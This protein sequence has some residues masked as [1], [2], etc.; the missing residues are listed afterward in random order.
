MFPRS[1]VAIVPPTTGAGGR[2]RIT[3]L[4]VL[5]DDM[6]N[7]PVPSCTPKLT[8][9]ALKPAGGSHGSS[10]SAVLEQNSIAIEPTDPVVSTI[11]LTLNV[12]AG[13]PATLLVIVIERGTGWAALA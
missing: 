1:Y 13:A 10:S 12:L 3:W 4:A 2:V 8:F 6:V 5:S 9:V 7:P 11:K